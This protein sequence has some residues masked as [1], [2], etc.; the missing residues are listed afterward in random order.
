MREIWWNLAD[1]CHGLTILGCAVATYLLFG[2]L[3]G[4]GTGGG[5][6]FSSVI[7]LSFVVIP[8]CAGRVFEGVAARPLKVDTSKVAPC[9]VCRSFVPKSATRCKH[10]QIVLIPMA[11]D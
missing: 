6:D 2:S 8:Y 9:P 4:M 1:I 10:C 7:G 5:P 11:S 3:F